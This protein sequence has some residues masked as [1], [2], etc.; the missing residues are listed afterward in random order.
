MAGN[1]VSYP[2][3]S[4][5]NELLWITIDLW[6]NTCRHLQS[7]SR[8]SYCIENF[9]IVFLNIYNCTYKTPFCKSSH[10]LMIFASF[11]TVYNRWWSWQSPGPPKQ[12]LDSS[13]Q[14]SIYSDR[15][16]T[17]VLLSGVSVV[18]IIIQ[19]TLAI[20]IKTNCVSN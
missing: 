6:R 10:I 15:T 18:I 3:H 8:Y 14:R 12:Q 5:Y 4:R 17:N 2:V 9:K 19:T 11:N 13:V 7:F 20:C 1:P 16:T